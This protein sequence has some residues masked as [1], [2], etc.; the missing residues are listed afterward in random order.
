MIKDNKKSSKM[1]WL[2]I[3]LA[4]IILLAAFIGIGLYRSAHAL[5][6]SHYSVSSDK[7]TNPIRI[8]Q[9]TDLHN[10]E[11][12]D[13][14]SQIVE[15]VAAE[16]PDLI[17]ITG[18]LLNSDENRTDIATDMIKG[19]APIAPVYVSY[20]NHEAA[21]EEK[22]GTDLRALYSEAG[23]TVLEYDWQDI[24]VNGQAVRLGG[25]FGYCMAAKYRETHEANEEECIFLDEFGAS[26][27]FK[28]LMCHMPLCWIVSSSLDD[29]GVDCV[30]AGH[31]HGGQIR[32][33]FVGGLWAPDQ[34]WFPGRSSGL[35]YSED[36][37]NV[38]V[39]SRGLGSREK[40]PRFNNVPEI[41]TLDLQPSS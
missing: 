3:L 25:I 12:G 39:V 20:G 11:F 26:D 13:H 17:L 6:V 23:A 14:N 40:I 28:V 9:L 33:P 15:K 22:Y 37:K 24:T 30:L 1:K 36:G 10:S 7:L 38:L 2:F 41:L 29:W 18:D 16:E 8:V 32:I 5:T 27:S 4:V 35:Y 19:L 34:G 21:F 31:I